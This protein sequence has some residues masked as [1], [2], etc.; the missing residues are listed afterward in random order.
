MYNFLLTVHSINRW[1]VLLTGLIVIFKSLSGWKSN[2]LYTKGDGAVH[3]AFVGFTHLQFLTG[4]LLYFVFSP[5]TEQIFADFGAAMKN[6]SLRFWAVEHTLG[7][8]IGTVLV[9]LGRTFSKKAPTDNL[10]FKRAFV[11]SL[12]ALIIILLSI[13]FGIINPETRPLFRF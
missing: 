12:I 7:M 11:Y 9:Q 6:S 10:K 8:F 4:I 2:R 13:P 5:I 3:G 1:L